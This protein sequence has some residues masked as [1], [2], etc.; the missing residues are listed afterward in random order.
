MTAKPKVTTEVLRAMKQAGEP[1]AALTAYD[2]LWA[3]LLDAAGVD[4]LLVGDSVGTVVQGHDTTVPVTMEN[5]LY[6][7]EMVARGTKRALVVADM[8]FMSFQ[9]SLKDALSNAGGLL[10]KSGAEAVKLEGGQPVLDTVQHITDA[11][12][13]VMGHL[14]LTPQSIHKFGS[15]KVRGDNPT[16]AKQIFD[17]A[18]ALQDAGIF[19]LVLEKIPGKLAGR[20]TKALDIPTIGI[21]AGP[22]CDGQILVTQD[23]I[24]LFTRFQPRFVRR[25]LALAE[26]VDQ[27]FRQFVGDVKNREFPNADESY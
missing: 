11:G 7:T 1:I 13:P 12:I 8:P 24:G 16:E 17:D 19:A 27:A 3:G 15:Y 18:R 5:I 21:G 6:H 14:G 20:I 9:V 22:E 26:T 10:K 4:V 25:Y 2:H 23:M